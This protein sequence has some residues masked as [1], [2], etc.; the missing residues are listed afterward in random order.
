MRHP[1]STA[2]VPPQKVAGA[3]PD[4]GT[5]WEDQQQGL[6]MQKPP[7]KKTTSEIRPVAAI[8]RV[9]QRIRAA[10]PPR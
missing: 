8:G 2:P 7:L 5:P 4:L 3:R 9:L 6:S 1:C 10:V